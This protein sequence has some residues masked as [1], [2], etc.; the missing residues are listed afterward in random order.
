MKLE[1]KQKHSAILALKNNGV[2]KHSVK[3]KKRDNVVPVKKKS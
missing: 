3:L 1:S 2:Q